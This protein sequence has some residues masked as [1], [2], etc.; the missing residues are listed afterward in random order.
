MRA[1]DLVRRLQNRDEQALS[2]LYDQY[3][4]ALMGIIARILNNREV[5]ED[6]LQKT[7]LK[8]WNGIQSFDAEKSS[9]FTWMATIARNAAIDQKRLKS[10]QHQEKTETIDALVHQ[11]QSDQTNTAGI[12]VQKLTANLDPKYKDVLDHIYLLGYTQQETSDQLGIPLGTV[13]TRLRLAI[14]A[15]GEKLENEK[16]LFL[17][18]LIILLILL[19]L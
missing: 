14:K 2:Y 1:E 15:L 18:L 13:K 8:V 19:L 17:G 9:L 10:F 4:G 6:I 5:A 3:S 12:D 11:P 16:G 7:M